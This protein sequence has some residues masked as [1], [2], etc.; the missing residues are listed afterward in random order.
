MSDLPV[1]PYIENPQQNAKDGQFDIS[2]A[3]DSDG[4]PV[5]LDWVKYVKVQTATFIDGGVFGEKSTEI[6]GVNLACDENFTSDK[7]DVKLR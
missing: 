2:W 3:V 1:N 4:M 6:N 5:H 7:A